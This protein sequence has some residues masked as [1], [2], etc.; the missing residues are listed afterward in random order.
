MDP[1]VDLFHAHIGG[2]D[3][4]ARALV[5]ASALIEE[6]TLSGPVAERYAGWEGEL[7]RGILGGQVDLAACHA[8]ALAA[9]AGPAPVSGRQ[10][11]LENRVRA[12]LE[13]SG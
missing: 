13:R 2:M 4:L 3:T 5:A 12:A 7:G 11:W 1:T 8:H 6:E 9:G 10:E